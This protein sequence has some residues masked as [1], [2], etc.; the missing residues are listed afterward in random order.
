[1]K[2]SIFIGYDPREAEAFAVC[3]HSLRR[4]SGDIPVYAIC[5]DEM[6]AL[7]LY[8]R[9]ME[10]RDGR[11]WDAISDA[12]C[13]T[14]FAIS[15][16]LTPVLAAEGWALFIDCDFLAAADVNELFD[17]ADPK[18]AVM[19]VKHEH[20]PAEA[21]KMDGQLQTLYK[22]K[23]WSSCMLFNCAHPANEALTVDLINSVPGRDLHAFSW[24]KDD[25]IGA[26]DPAWNFLVGHTD[27]SIKP[28][29]IHWTSGGPWFDGYRKV[30]FAA[31]WFAERVRWLNDEILEAA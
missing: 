24:L 29:L 4:L 18:Y 22:R 13:A 9:S 28:K 14:E 30:P 11:L 10:K 31:E 26:L 19:C 1:V 23:N 7:K 2:R 3:R 21:I 15:R 16:F 27:P 17:Q 20:N 6:R 5:L 8:W 25:E 12:P